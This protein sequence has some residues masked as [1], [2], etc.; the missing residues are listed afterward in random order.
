VNTAPGRAAGA[1][2]GP[3]GAVPRRF[4][5]YDLLEV[6]GRGG[7][8]VVFKARQRGLAR[9]V[10]LKMILAGRDAGEAE[11]A[12]FKT[13]AEAAARLQHPNIVQIH[14][15]GAHH[16]RAYL[17]LE[18]CPGGGLDRKLSGTPLPPG[19]AARLVETLGRA[20]HAAHQA[21][22]V[23]RD[24]KPA[25]VLLAAD[26]TPKVSDFGL[27]KMLDEAGQTASGAVMGTP[28][29]MAPEQ[30]GYRPGAPAAGV[31]PAADVYALGAILYECL[32]GRPPFRAPTALETLLQVQTDEPVPPRQLQ[33][34]TPR[35]LETICLKCLHKEPAKR[36]ATAE[37]LAEDL[38]RWLGG[39]PVVARPA[40]R[41]ERLGKWARRRPA[42]A[43]LLAVTAAAALAVAGVVVASNIRLQRERDRADRRREEAESQR[44]RAL[45]HLGQTRN[46]VDL[47][48]EFG[49]ERLAPVPGAEQV[50]RELLE[51]ALR[52]SQDLARQESDDPELRH[53]VGLAHRRLGKIYQEFGENGK[54][55]QSF[56]AAV[57]VQEELTAAFPTVRAY[58]Q[59]L[60]RSHNNLAVLLHQPPR[61]QESEAAFRQAISLQEQLV[62]DFPE[63]PEFQQD[64]GESYSA[65]GQVLDQAG[66]PP[67]AEQA[68]RRSVDLLERAVAGS[69]AEVKFQRSLANCNNNWVVFQLRHGR[70]AGAE[71]VFRRD[72]AFFEERARQSPDDPGLRA[73][74]AMS[75]YNLATCWPGTAGSGRRSKSSAAPKSWAGSWSA[76]SRACRITT[77]PW[78]GPCTNWGSALTPAG[79]T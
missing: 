48:T 61:A 22:V 20:V 30:A 67:E 41:L 78:D 64:L 14:E 54:A 46:A 70:T 24:L 56:R 73:R 58:R 75:C 27:A 28:S 13:E 36:Y 39:E 57:A 69:P 2:P 12:R 35:D 26:G 60:A 68:F 5:G 6:L 1:A 21:G 17:A 77:R 45:T 51:L 31:G 9:L 34:R 19:E 65:L 37:A 16:G 42:V 79:N 50:R 29:Y 40:G 63:E 44:Q 52:F 74:V 33:P 23:H 8:G 62:K 53:D 59:E 49:F 3:D 55:E 25:N 76:I 66:R 47:L 18:F 11:L 7:M 10:A 15:V 4:G 71:H 72:L 38:E 43:A 32:T